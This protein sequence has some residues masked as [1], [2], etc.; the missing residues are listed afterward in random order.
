MIVA[1][2]FAFDCP[3]PAWKVFPTWTLVVALKRCRMRDQNWGMFFYGALSKVALSKDANPSSPTLCFLMLSFLQFP[4][5]SSRNFL[6]GCHFSLE[7]GHPKLNQSDLSYCS[8]SY[9]ISHDSSWPCTGNWMGT[10]TR[11]N[12]EGIQKYPKQFWHGRRLTFEES[13]HSSGN[14]WETSG[15]ILA[16]LLVPNTRWK[17]VCQPHSQN[18]IKKGWHAW[19]L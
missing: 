6:R 11:M 3:R 10:A 13:W 7:T 14:L 12:H 16:Q 5:R 8:L 18:C 4:Q 1:C 17:A 19:K 9:L 2:H 15:G